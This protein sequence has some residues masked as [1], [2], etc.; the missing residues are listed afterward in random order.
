MDTIFCPNCGEKN[1]SSSGFCGHCGSKLREIIRDESSF[2]SHPNFHSMEE[3]VLTP[4]GK[5]HSGL[6][7]ASFIIGLVAGAIQFF[8]ILGSGIAEYSAVGGLG[9]EV[10]MLVGLF[11]CGGMATGV[12]G[13]IL[14]IIGLTQKNKKKI[15]SILGTI[16]NS[17]TII[18]VIILW[19]IGDTV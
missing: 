7:I 3:M 10:Y 13:L 9:D 17:L 8:T 16:I 4:E 15:F 11:I 18:L 1:P 14:G 12:V 2:S 5:K 6:G 19:F